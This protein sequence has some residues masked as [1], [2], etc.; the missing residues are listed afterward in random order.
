METPAAGLSP[1]LQTGVLNLDYFIGGVFV[2]VYA[3]SRFNTP[4]TNRST[5]T[6][7]R[8]HVAS[9]IYFGVGLLLFGLLAAYQPLQAAV[10]HT[11]P[12]LGLDHDASDVAARLSPPLLAALFLTGLLPVAAWLLRSGP[13]FRL[14]LAS[15]ASHVPMSRRQMRDWSLS[16]NVPDPLPVWAGRVRL[17]CGGYARRRIAMKT[18]STWHNSTAVILGWAVLAGTGCSALNSQTA[19]TTTVASPADKPASGERYD[20]PKASLTVRAFTV[21]APKAKDVAGDGLADMLA[22]ALFESNRFIVIEQQAAPAAAVEQNLGASHR[23]NAGGA[24]GIGQS[25]SA[26]LVVIGAITEFEPGAAGAKVS[27]PDYGGATNQGRGKNKVANS[28]GKLVGGATGSVAMSH[29]AIDLRVVDARTSRVVAATSVAGRATDVDLSGLGKGAGSKLGGGLSLYARTP[30]EKAIRLAIRD[31]VQFVGSQTPKEYYRHPD[32]KD[33]AVAS[34]AQPLDR[35]LVE[36]PPAASVSTPRP[37]ADS[38]KTTPQPAVASS[39]ASS[40]PAKVR[41]INAA[42]ANIR[43]GPGKDKAILTTVKRATKIV[44]VEDRNDWYRV[45]LENGREGWVA[46]SVTSSERP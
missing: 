7:L 26:D 8:Y 1:A 17:A 42:E 10:R 6:W 11:L 46:A 13:S 2:I 9:T 28:M 29:V 40:V 18:M 36:T 24:P 15:P 19:P 32:T 14:G 35:G 3:A 27:A 37:P 21:K 23:V 41:Y 5:T 31:A 45:K 4:A 38:S 16:L 30:M 12:V 22:T 39:T 43:M 44:V 33:G 25:E 20:G 34:K